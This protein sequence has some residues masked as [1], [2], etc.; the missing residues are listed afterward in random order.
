MLTKHGTLIAT[1]AYQCNDNGRLRETNWS[2]VISR[3]VDANDTITLDIVHTALNV[4][5][6]YI[7]GVHYNGK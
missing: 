1:S 3:G 2:E 5:L 6:G 4:S 7:P